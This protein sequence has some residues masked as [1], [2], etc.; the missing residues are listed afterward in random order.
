M[1]IIRKRFPDGVLWAGLGDTTFVRLKL[2]AWGRALGI[3]IVPER[4][5]EACRERLRAVLANRRVLIIVDD[6][7]ATAGS[8]VE[9]INTLKEKGVK[10]VYAAVS[11]GVFASEDQLQQPPDS[12]QNP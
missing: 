2:E 1:G 7:C 11:H 10:E 8:M 3:D 9:A 4:S 12:Y 5:D 6:I